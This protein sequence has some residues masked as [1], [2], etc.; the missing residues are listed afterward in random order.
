[1]RVNILLMFLIMTLYSVAEENSMNNIYEIRAKSSGGEEILLERYKGQV[2]LI[3]NVASKCGF[4][5]QY[6]GLEK[7]YQEYRDRGFV[8]LG[9]PANNFMNQEPGTDEEILNF[10]RLNYGV[11]FPIFGKISVRGKDI[12]PIYKYLTS[13][14]TNPDFS[15]KITWN[16]NKFLISREG[17]IINRFGSNVTPEST[18]LIDAVEVALEKKHD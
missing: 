1:M 18:A 12:H 4:T 15:G 7:I 13:K 5:P 2:I 9:F 16:F 8:I 11:S 10:C 3:V 17:K 6:E 14:D